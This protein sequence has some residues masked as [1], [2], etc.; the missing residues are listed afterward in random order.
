MGLRAPRAGDT[1]PGTAGPGARAARGLAQGQRRRPRAW[2]G[3]REGLRKVSLQPGESGRCAVRCAR[4]SG[5]CGAGSGAG[6]GARRLE[7]VCVRAEPGWT[8]APPSGVCG[9]GGAGGG[10]WRGGGRGLG[11]RRGRG[12]PESGEKLASAWV[13]ADG[14]GGGERGALGPGGDAGRG[15]AAGSESPQSRHPAGQGA[16][17]AGSRIPLPPFS[18]LLVLFAKE[19]SCAAVCWAPAPPPPFPHL[20]LSPG[21]FLSS[22]PPYSKKKGGGHRGLVKNP[23]H[24]G[25]G[26]KG[27]SA[28]S[29]KRGTCL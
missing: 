3:G 18:P 19:S 24:E 4:G 6:E 23:R 2:V 26:G 29:G 20:R 13:R 10:V 8:L 5:A 12:E 25:A 16:G 15:V 22:F 21:M 27:L 1:E 17:H 28:Q 7:E 11:E 14:A 9:G